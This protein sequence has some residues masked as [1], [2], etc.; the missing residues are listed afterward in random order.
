[1]GATLESHAG[2]TFG[3][4]VCGDEMTAATMLELFAVLQ[5]RLAGDGVSLLRYRAVPYVYHRAP[6]GEDLYALH[7]L[8]ARVVRRAPLSA[9]DQRRPLPGQTRRRRGLQRAAKSG[10]V[11]GENADL[12]GYWAL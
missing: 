10:L 5:R 4:W 8:G 3:G 11:C 1:R 9:I 2:L 12:A 6:A 7:H